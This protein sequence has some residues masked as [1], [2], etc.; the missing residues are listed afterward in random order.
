MDEQLL[1][2]AAVQH[3]LVPEWSPT[4]RDP[5]PTKINTQQKKDPL[6][7]YFIQRQRAWCWSGRQDLNLRPLDPQSSALPSC[8]TSRPHPF[9]GVQLA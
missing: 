2:F 6:T 7:W 3:T 5:E 1:Y 8:A 9:T 4:Q